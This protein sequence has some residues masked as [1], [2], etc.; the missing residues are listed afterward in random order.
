MTMD[1]FDA[2]E[3]RDPAQR[4]AELLARLPGL[5]AAACRAP[6]WRAHLGELDPQAITSRAALARLPVLRKGDAGRAAEGRSA[7]CRAGAG[8]SRRLRAVVHV[9]RADLRTR[10][11]PRRSVAGGAR[12]LR[13]GV[14]AQRHRAQHV[15]L[16]PDARRLHR[17][18][19]C[20]RGRVRRDS[21]RARQQ[22]AAARCDRAAAADR[23]HRHAGLPQDPARRGRARGSRRDLSAARGGLRRGVSGFAAGGDQGARDRRLPDV[24]D[25]G[26]RLCRLRDR[27]ARRHGGQRGHP[28]RDRAAGNWRAG[29]RW[30][31]RRG[32]RDVRS[33]P[34]IRGSA[35][36]S[37][38]CRRC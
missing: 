10:R 28:A 6:R 24:C 30:R 35:W 16:P 19:R 22:R 37:A 11:A 25:R 33:T 13:R 3:T 36:P 32:R 27:R 17:R 20:A 7:I 29:C 2:R 31:G 4:E 12:A 26:C 18:L 5:V 34:T 9:A 38:T 1:H 14:P 8:R 23:V 21:G 15:L